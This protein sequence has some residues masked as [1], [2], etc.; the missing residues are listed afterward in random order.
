MQGGP[1]VITILFNVT[2]KEGKGQDCYDLAVRLTE[3]TRTEDDGCLTYFFHQGQDNPME[4]VL[5]EQWRDREA[6]DAHMA[7]LE[8]LLGPPNPGGRLPAALLDL[9]ESTQPIF[10]DVVA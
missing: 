1:K 2:G 8:A 10:Y 4:Y 3:V 6:L 7:H 9:C 5:Y